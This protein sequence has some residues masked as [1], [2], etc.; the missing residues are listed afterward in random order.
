MQLYNLVLTTNILLGERF[1]KRWVV[2]GPPLWGYVEARGGK[3]FLHTSC[4]S[5]DTTDY[6]GE[7]VPEKPFSPAEHPMPNAELWI[8]YFVL[9]TNS[10]Y[11]PFQEK[12]RA[13][14]RSDISRA[15]K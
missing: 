4:W 12:L 11:K 9:S 3:Y 14:L 7:I 2:G 8:G 13:D 5:Y 6:T 10:D 15:Q 1:E